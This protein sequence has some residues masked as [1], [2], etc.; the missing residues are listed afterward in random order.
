M[1][2]AGFLEKLLDGASVEWKLLGEIGELVRGN[3]L[4]SCIIEITLQKIS[5]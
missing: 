1:R 5:T 4:Q 3:G 2:S